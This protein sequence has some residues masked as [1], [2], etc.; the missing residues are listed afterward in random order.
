M[1]FLSSH[2]NDDNFQS[3]TYVIK[4]IGFIFFE[5]NANSKA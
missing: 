1:V 5:Y 4:A 2:W 3:L